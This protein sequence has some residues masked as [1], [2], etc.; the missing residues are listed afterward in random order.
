M[1]EAAMTRSCCEA[2]T[3]IDGLT[4]RWIDGWIEV[5]GLTDRWIDR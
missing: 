5:D 4:D 1:I 2:P 3:M